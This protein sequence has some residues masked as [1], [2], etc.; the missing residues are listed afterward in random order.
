M[1]AGTGRDQSPLGCVVWMGWLVVGNLVLLGIAL[2]LM[3]KGHWTLGFLDV[4]YFGVMAL[5]LCLRYVDLTRF[6]GRTADGA[7]AP[8]GL[9]PRYA[10][11]FAGTWVALWALAH[12]VEWLS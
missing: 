1:P 8:P 10:A 2:T 9:F 7:P 11:R 6:G 4:V 3:R 12:S 5:T